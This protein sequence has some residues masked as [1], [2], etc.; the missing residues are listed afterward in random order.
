MCLI[1]SKTVKPVEV[2]PDT[3]SKNAF[4]KLNY[5]YLNKMVLIK[6]KVLKSNNSTV[7][8]FSNIEDFFNRF[9]II[10]IKPIVLD[11]IKLK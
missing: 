4:K 2:K 9:K 10:K 3:A 8:I 5:K 7:D 6:P 1:F 11:I